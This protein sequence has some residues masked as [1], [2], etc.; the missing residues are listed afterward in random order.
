MT[1]ERVPLGWGCRKRIAQTIRDR[2]TD[3]VLTL[4]DNQP[5]LHA[6]VVETFAAEQ[7]E[8]FEGCD[9]KFHKTVQ[10]NRGRIETR[11][12]RALGTP[13]YTRYVDPDGAWPDLHSLVM[14]EAQQRRDEQAVS[15]TRYDISSLPA[16]AQALVQAVRSHWGGENHLH[17]VLNM[18]F[19]EDASHIRTGHA[20]HNLSV[21]PAPGDHR[22][23]QPRRPAQA[24]RLK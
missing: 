14:I 17:W 15:E 21:V 12:Y 6:A 19:R 8:S 1:I 9:H 10:K 2:G 4:K 11:R 24:G 7:A 13:E 5:P 22:Q 23:G 16:A 20:A 18:A 3:H